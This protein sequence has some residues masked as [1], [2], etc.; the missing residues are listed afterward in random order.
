L[1]VVR[2]GAAIIAVAALCALLAGPAQA[3][4]T[5]RI[6][7]AFA[8]ERLGAPTAI[9]LG[10][11][12]KGAA[13]EPPAPLTGIDFRYPSNLGIATSGLG[14][15]ACLP[16][17]Y[18]A[19]GPAACPGNS[20]MGS[21]TALVDVP[22]GPELIEET[23]RLTL[24]AGPSPDSLL[25]VLIGATGESPVAARIVI[26][27]VLAGGKLRVAVPLVEGLPEGPDVSVVKVHVTIGGALTYHERVHGRMVSYHPK[28]ISLPRSCPRGGFR[29]AAAFAFLDGNHAE[30]RA[31]VPCPRGRR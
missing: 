29:F 23:A 20:L 4:E 9:S 19:H 31:V 27:T 18:V 2:R 11:E 25:H 21:G 16:A 1:T 6:S 24:A 12:V 26:P 17:A 28:G 8:P 5:A 22:V 3:V 10:F 30:A 15:A 13:G 7:A 14:T